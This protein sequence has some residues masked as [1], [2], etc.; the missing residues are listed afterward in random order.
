LCL[1]QHCNGYGG[2]LGPDNGYRG[3][4]GPDNGYRGVLGP[5]REYG[6]STQN[7]YSL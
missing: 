1:G 2:V 3:V 7:C 6:M 5:E 4:L